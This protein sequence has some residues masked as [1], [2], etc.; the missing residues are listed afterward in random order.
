MG[1][2][3][4]GTLEKAKEKGYFA[5]PTKYYIIDEIYDSSKIHTIYCTLD[6]SVE[7]LIGKYVFEGELLFQE[8]ELLRAAIN[9][10]II[11]FNGIEN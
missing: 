10:D 1:Q 9:G 7:Q 3:H 5:D 8:G 2:A 6:T 11:I 4:K